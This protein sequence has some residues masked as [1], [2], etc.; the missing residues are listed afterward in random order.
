MQ[1]LH[2]YRI[3]HAGFY[4][5]YFCKDFVWSCPQLCW[6]YSYNILKTFSHQTEYMLLNCTCKYLFAEDVN[7]YAHEI[8]SYK[9]FNAV[10]MENPGLNQILFFHCDLKV[11]LSCICCE[12]SCLAK[13][14]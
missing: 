5:Y 7:V 14:G 9:I 12:K 6:L 8:F 3:I 13:G 10:Q 11:I 2:K 1:E 4:L